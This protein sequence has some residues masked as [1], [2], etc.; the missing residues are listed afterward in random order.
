MAKHTYGLIGYPLSHSFSREYFTRYFEDQGLAD[1]HQYLNFEIEQASEFTDIRERYPSLRGANVTIPHKVAIMPQLDAI[2]RV[3]KDIGAVNTIRIEDDGTAIGFNTDY[4]GFRL[5]M[6]E[7]MK[8]ADWTQKAHNMPYTI[9]NLHTSLKKSNALVLGSGGASKAIVAA[10]RSFGI[11]PMVVSRTP[12]KA[13]I[14]YVEL[15]PEH[16]RTYEIIVNT[17]P[18]GMAPGI[19]TFPP[20]PYELIGPRHFVYD[21]VYNPTE[22][23]F[24]R[25]CRERGA[26]VA[27][28]MGML[29]EQARQ[30]WRIWQREGEHV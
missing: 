4:V 26:S 29:E 9:D 15:L 16:I 18:L 5:D 1:D 25:K 24:L 2:D 12:G 30:S 23:V 6:L 7:K 22:T 21:L 14:A 11:A 8:A 19:E 28:G 27:N 17:T 13:D 10:L 20:I 3:A